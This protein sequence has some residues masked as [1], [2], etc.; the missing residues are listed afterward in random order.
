MQIQLLSDLHLERDRAHAEHSKESYHY[1]IPAAAP[2]LALLGD[3]GC[4]VHEE[5]FDWLRAQLQR[6]EKVL[7]VAGNHEPYGSSIASSHARLHAFAAASA[8]RFVF[9][10]QTRLDLGPTLTV[11]GCTLWAAL[12]ARR[13]GALQDFAHIADFD[14]RAY[15][16]A[17]RADVAW[18]NGAVARLAAEEPRRR[19]VVLTHH[20]PTR[21]GTSDPRF[22]A[23][24]HPVV[25]AFGSELSGEA[26]WTAGIV[27]VWAF[28][29]THW[30][31]DFERAGVRV[32]SNQRGYRDGGEGYDPAKVISLKE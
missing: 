22:A 11:L 29:H 12:D 24:D 19:V 25:S 15:A 27:V 32:V 26:C 28:G 17:H 21:A 13:A 31:C 8:G 5:L 18:L 7:Y 3:I 1:D 20:A 9:L 14:P 23:D 6:F 30:C 2:Y 16:A 10:Q 4:T